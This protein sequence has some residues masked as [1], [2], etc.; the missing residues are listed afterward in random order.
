MAGASMSTPACAAPLRIQ[1]IWLFRIG[2]GM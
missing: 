2:C 1:S